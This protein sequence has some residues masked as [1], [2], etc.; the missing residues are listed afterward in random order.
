MR[1]GRRSP[2]HG[3]KASTCTKPRHSQSECVLLCTNRATDSASS[4]SYKQFFSILKILTELQALPY[5]IHNPFPAMVLV[6]AGS[7]AR[8]Y[9]IRKRYITR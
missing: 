3:A 9:A 2:P 8:S 4:V 1:G 5:C 6:T 7:H